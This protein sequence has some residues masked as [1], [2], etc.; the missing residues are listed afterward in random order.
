M[1]SKQEFTVT[2]EYQYNRSSPA[3][4]ITSHILHYKFY[5]IGFILTA[6]LA[7]VLINAFIAI[8]TGSAF[9]AV[10][11][12]EAGR[13]LL[14]HVALALVSVICIGIIMDLSARLS[15]EVLGK[16]VARDARNELYLSLLGKSQT[17]HNR[18]R[19]GDIM[20]RASND[21]TSLS[22][23]IV[24][25][26]DIIFDSFLSIIVV[27][28]SIAFLNVQL[29]L[30]P[31][32]FV[33]AFLL[34]LRSYSRKLNPISNQMR[35]Q[36]GVTNA[37]LNESVTGIEVVKATAQEEQEQRKFAENASL[38]RD[39]F[40]R[41]GQLQGRYLP[42]LLVAFALAGAFLHA[43]F[44][45]LHQ[46]ISLGTLVAYM[47]LMGILRYPTY[48]SIWTFSLVQLGMAGSGRILNLMKEETELDENEAGY[49]GEMQGDIVFDSVTFSYGNAP[50]LKNISFHAQPGQTVAIVGQTGSGKSSMTK[51]VNRI[52]DVDAGRVLID[53]RDVR[54]WNLD[55]LRSQISTIE[56]DI[57][58]FSRSVAENIAYG[59]G[60]KANRAA[61]EQA[62]KD[63]QADNFIQEFKDGYETAIGERGVTL[64]GGQRQRIAIARALLTDPRIL[65]LDD[66][67]SA[68]DSATEDEIQKAIR[69]LLQGRTTLLITH[70][71]SQIRWADKIL[72]LRKGELIDQGTH[73][74]LM[75]RSSAYRRIFSHYDSPLPR[76]LQLKDDSR[77]VSLPPS[78]GSLSEEGVI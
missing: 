16:R 61:I 26:M 1:S 29:L 25:A 38:Y 42:T 44:L 37:V 35:A 59:L 31:S 32:L 78:S 50:I 66:S 14:V 39:Y 23:M 6:L 19:V 30:A 69:R 70:R 62:A 49:R 27:L 75:A 34:S 15:A 60:Q 40:V 4:W 56:Q 68:I 20:A 54:D 74:E 77:D 55:S 72:F 2:G 7:N 52:Y 64:S 63:A 5:A 10:S 3:R 8:L 47:G 11:R 45:V 22:D 28:I 21:M 17:F 73:D 43:L 51:L 65:I 12:G 33:V 41:N 18:Q 9:D 24:P 53:G 67:T 58:L 76:I 57:F 13:T 46:Q 48:L 71:L 36:F